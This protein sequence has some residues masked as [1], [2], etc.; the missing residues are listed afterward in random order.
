LPTGCFSN[1]I[2]STRAYYGSVTRTAIFTPEAR[3]QTFRLERPSLWK[4]F[5]DYL[6]EGIWHIWKG[7]DHILFLISLLLPAVVM[8]REHAW[9]PV[10][11]FREAFMDV[12]K[13][14]TSFTVAHSIT[15]SLATFG[16]VRLPARISES[17][18]AA[19]VVIAA[20]N[21]IFPLIGGRRWLVAF[22]FGLIHG[23]GFANVLADLG[24]PQGT[25]VLALVGFNLGVEV[26]Q[27]AIVSAFLPAAF[28]LRSG[29]FYRRLVL[30]G[31]SAAIS[32]LAG[33][34]FIGRAFNVRFLPAYLGN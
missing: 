29:W 33:M 24:L 2:R 11:T 13:I 4:Q 9:Q 14:V 22:C 1:S 7:Y 10:E 15:L 23:F 28:W 34:W 3:E 12:L 17:A 5:A 21:N 25:L 16:V 20:L 32:V 18:I 30:L 6:V 26:G 27:L 8:R 31:G 19:S